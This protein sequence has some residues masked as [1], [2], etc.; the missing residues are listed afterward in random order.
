MVLG[1]NLCSFPSRPLQLKGQLIVISLRRMIVGKIV[2]HR[3]CEGL[4]SQHDRFVVKPFVEAGQKY[5]G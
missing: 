2:L 1:I 4:S 5:A 3:G